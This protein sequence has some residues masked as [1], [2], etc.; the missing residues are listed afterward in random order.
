MADDEKEEKVLKYKDQ[1]REIPTT[2]EDWAAFNNIADRKSF[3][4]VFA[5]M[6][7]KKNFVPV[8]NNEDRINSDAAKG[9]LN[10]KGWALSFF[11][12]REQAKGRLKYFTRDKAQMYLKLGTHIAEGVIKPNDGITEIECDKYTHF[13]HFE[14][15]DTDFHD[16]RFEIVEPVFE[17]PNE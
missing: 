14:Y 8:Y 11:E 1:I 10:F 15:K 5:D 6:A 16:N 4:W 17:E 2:D 9:K 12:D 13:N 7:D 3:R